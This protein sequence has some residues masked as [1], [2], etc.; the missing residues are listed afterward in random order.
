MTSLLVYICVCL[1]ACHRLR[2][3]HRRALS[4]RARRA[5]CHDNQGV[6]GAEVLARALRRNRALRTLNLGVNAIGD[7]GAWELASGEGYQYAR[8]PPRPAPHARHAQHGAGCRRWLLTHRCVGR[9]AAPPLF[10]SLVGGSAGGEPGAGVAGARRQRHHLAGHR[11]L[12]LL[13]GHQRHAALP[14]ARHE[15]GR[16][17]R[18]L[19]HRHHA[20]NPPGTPCACHLLLLL[21]YHPLPPRHTGGAV[22][23]GHGVSEQQRDRVAGQGGQVAEGGGHDC[24]LESL[25]LSGN[26]VT[27]VGAAALTSALGS[28][29]NLKYINLCANFLSAPAVRSHPPHPPRPPRLIAAPPARGAPACHRPRVHHL[30]PARRPASAR[31]AGGGAAGAGAAAA[32]GGA[33]AGARRLPGER[34]SGGEAPAVSE[35]CHRLHGTSC[36]PSCPRSPR[37]RPTVPCRRGGRREKEGGRERADS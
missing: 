13:D 17:R 9:A 20:H 25:D 19:S 15:Q 18:R 27:D 5:P 32:R 21:L 14:L 4:S 12:P 24:V 31:P 30:R 37:P 29:V 28:N 2:H 10:P 1:C 3:R 8:A 23:C 36:S 33:L 11:V 6:D 35:S 16:R 22:P 26:G 34:A 7:E